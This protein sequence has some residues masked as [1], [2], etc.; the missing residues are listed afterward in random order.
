MLLPY[1]VSGLTLWPV[2]R[3]TQTFP[4]PSRLRRFGFVLWLMSII[5]IPMLLW[6]TPTIMVLPLAVYG[7][8]FLLFAASV[9]RYYLKNRHDF[10]NRA[11]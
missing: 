5:L 8:V 9:I 6:V 3:H 7:A 4:P 11:E 1:A 10:R 2:A